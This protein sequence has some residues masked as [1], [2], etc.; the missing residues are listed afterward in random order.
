M[1]GTHLTLVD[2]TQKSAMG[3]LLAVLI[4]CI[5][6]SSI[7]A[8]PIFQFEHVLP[9]NNTESEQI[10]TI[11]SML[12]DRM[13]FIWFVGQNIV[14][15]DGATFKEFTPATGMPCSG[16]IRDIKEDKRGVIWILSDEN[17]CFLNEEKMAFEPLDLPTTPA[18][19]LASASS[20]LITSDNELYIGLNNKLAVIN[21]ARNAL[22]FYH[23]PL[24][25]DGKNDF[26]CMLLDGDQIWIGSRSSGLLSF[27]PGNGQ[28]DYVANQ[29]NSQYLIPHNNI[30]SLAKDGNGNLWLASHEGGLSRID[31]KIK[32]VRNYH[33][34]GKASQFSRN[35]WH[36]MVDTSGQ[37]WIGSDGDGLVGYDATHDSFFSYRNN[38]LIK[39]SIATNKAISLL[40]D[41]DNNI[42]ISLYPSGIELID[43]K[44]SEI[45]T[46][47]HEPNNSQ[48]LNSNNIVSIYE[49]TRDNIWIG[50][51]K[52]LN[53]LDPTNGV[54]TNYS[55]PSTQ[56]WNIN[57]S[58]ITSISETQDGNLWFGTWGAGLFIVNPKTGSTKHFTERSGD[59]GT[60]D[61]SNIWAILPGENETWIAGEGK[62]G[63]LIYNHAS[64]LFK[65]ELFA[66]GDLELSADHIYA[67]L[68][69]RSGTIWF[70]SLNGLYSLDTYNRLSLHSL[71]RATL[72]GNKLPSFRIRSLYEA[73]NGVIWI[74]TQD[75]GV[76]TWDPKSKQ[77]NTPIKDPS[78]NTSHITRIIA[79]K[80][81]LIWLF[82]TKGVLR[83]N[84]LDS[85]HEL[86]NHNH[87]LASENI[88]RGAAYLDD[89]GTAY[90]GG[91]NGLSIFNTASIG[92][93]THN[94]PVHV[95]EIS[96]PNPYKAPNKNTDKIFDT[97]HTSKITLNHFQNTFF[98]NFS[99]LSFPNSNQNEYAIK[100]DTIDHDWIHIG[101]KT[102]VAYANFPYGAYK[103]LVKA[104]DSYGI[105]STQLDSI[106][107][108]ILP[109]P[110]RTLWA[111]V[112][113]TCAAVLLIIGAG[114]LLVKRTEIRKQFE[115]TQALEKLRHEK[116]LARRHFIAD[117][118]HE[119][120]TP[121]S[122]LAGEIEAIEDG[123]RPLTPHS[124]QSLGIEVKLLNKLVDDLFELSLADFNILSPN[125]TKVDL[126]DAIDNVISNMK[127][128]HH[129]KSIECTHKHNKQQLFIKADPSR[130]HQLFSNIL[131]NCFRYTD[132]P[133]FIKIISESINDA[134][135]I[136]ILDSKPGLSDDQ[137]ELIFQ[138][139]YRAEASRNRAS[140]GAGLG[141]SICRQIADSHNAELKASHSD[142]G[143]ICITI[144][145]KEYR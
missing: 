126:I 117:I 107:I 106:E 135:E 94:F 111:Y 52:G 121:I 128:K 101:K 67:L 73:S 61:I 44:K 134:I 1:R 116:D 81:G 3:W 25:D 13:G 104:K 26:R 83:V 133:G 7:L 141:L 130:L 75:S 43:R 20:L 60:I 15:Y 41:Q 39:S 142:L 89:N 84:P 64:G 18:K 136:N 99:A 115:A 123:I 16:V 2:I 69:D 120:K 138:R 110:W 50:T 71:H 24:N 74:G 85:T 12:Q 58:S 57:A 122:I 4:I 102:T 65:R 68:R 28:F 33:S 47:H 129:L 22:H 51:E 76:Y 59:S 93:R 87:G 82:T 30:R 10:G 17:L 27:T 100:V 21:S 8:Q 139:F 11:T 32:T 131:E 103:I 125:F 72:P 145:F 31:L 137:L 40:E 78:L 19:S 34:I 63:I 88:Y 80:D 143:G 70:G 38:P 5:Y 48:S 96:I 113:Y 124:I 132:A 92:L 97:T 9:A 62:K 95:T 6:P 56:H 105:W 86:F 98:V 46:Y 66:T 53:R 90:V 45:K 114:V 108:E 36:L 119:L 42:W 55:A 140:G 37:L 49:D 127:T 23:A 144:S 91:T 109:P 29:I 112:I 54:F 35:L 79:G 118:S 77:F 14:R